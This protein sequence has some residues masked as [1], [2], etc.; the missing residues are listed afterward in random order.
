MI[1]I[2][3]II[4]LTNLDATIVLQP[5]QILL[6]NYLQLRNIDE[7][8]TYEQGCCSLLQ[9]LQIPSLDHLLCINFIQE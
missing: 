1:L 4:A 7:Y 6:R 8:Q 9:S 3:Y 5:L 2:I